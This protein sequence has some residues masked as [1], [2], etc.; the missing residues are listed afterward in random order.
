MIDS[1]PAVCQL[2]HTLNVGGAEVLAGNLA[3]RLKER[4]RF[5]FLCLDELGP[6]AD[7]LRSDGFS[8]EVVGRRSGLDWRCPLRLA[9]RWRRE[10]IDVVQAH[11]YTPFFYA[12]LARFRHRGMPVV[13]TE[14]GR[15][16]PDFPRPK[17]K[18]ANRLLL[19][20]RD[21]VVAVGRS[22]KQ[23]LIDNEGIPGRRI[24]VIPNGI[25][26]DRFAPA[27]G[28]RAAARRELAIGPA[29]YLVLMVARLDPIKDHATAVRACAAAAVSVPGLKLVLVGDGPERPAIERLVREQNLGGLVRLLGTRHDVPRLLTAADTLLLTSV[30]EGI[31]LTLIEAMATGVPVVSTAVGSVPDVVSP[32]VGF[33][34]PAGDEAALAGHLATLGRSPLL[35]I[36]MGD[37]G[38]ARAVENFSETAWAERYAALFDELLTRRP[39]PAAFAAG[40][41]DSA[42]GVKPRSS[43]A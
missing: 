8:V 21:R 34:A 22:V 10:R 33:L 5:S 9:R 6:G 7:R 18:V 12:L 17:R 41:S 43:H 42:S 1:R 20:R 11:Q 3:R 13:F 28:T 38:R 23:A 2:V 30:S 32:A 37:R 36:A 35:R 25:D 26:T 31:P 16:F 40:A 39:R 15:H 4:Y 14:H 29:D 24:E 27:A 19:A